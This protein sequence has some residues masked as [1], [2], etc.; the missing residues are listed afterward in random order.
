MAT[1]SNFLMLSKLI[2]FTE[3]LPHYSIH[4]RVPFFSVSHKYLG[5]FQLLFHI[6][7]DF[8]RIDHRMNKTQNDEQKFESSL[9]KERTARNIISFKFKIRWS[10]LNNCFA[11][12][13]VLWKCLNIN[14][15]FHFGIFPF[16][17]FFFL[18][19]QRQWCIFGDF[20]STFHFILFFSNRIYIFIYS[21]SSFFKPIKTSTLVRIALFRI[22]IFAIAR[23]RKKR[24]FNNLNLC[25]TQIILFSQNN[26]VC[27]CMFSSRNNQWCP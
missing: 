27:V 16:F 14:V 20:R 18:D 5:I 21:F 10:I 24:N 25:S 8:S 13:K 6:V 15:S 7:L 3:I 12:V 9:N 22:S 2:N 1:W 4:P 11:Y 17:F 23:R 19:F 26:F